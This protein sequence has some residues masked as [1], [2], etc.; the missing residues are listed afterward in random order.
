MAKSH[1]ANPAASLR[2]HQTYCLP[3]LLS[4]LP[5]LILSSSEIKLIDQRFKTTSQRLQK[6][7]DKTPASVVYFLG[8]HLPGAALLHHRQLT[9]FG[10]VSRLK[11]SLLHQTAV[12]TLTSIN[13]SRSSWF[14][15]IRELVLMYGLPSPLS[16]LFHPPTKSVYKRLI[17]AKILDFWE[18]KLRREITNLSSL[19]YFKPSYMSL[20]SPHP[21]WQTCGSNPYE[22]HKAII[23]ARMLSGRYPTEDLSKHWTDNR[24]L[25]SLPT[26][27]GLGS[28][29]HLLVSCPA[30]QSVRNRMMT[31]AYKVAARSNI[32]YPIVTWVLS[33]PYR[34]VLVQFLLDCSTIP[35]VISSSQTYGTDIMSELFYITRNWCYGLHRKRMELLNLPEYR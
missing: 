5:T 21:L 20:S 33:H 10:M 15:K 22:V 3:V 32:I 26:C 27:S 18:S 11:D 9:I 34:V 28:I 25:C 23:Q 6:L 31:L 14:F 30:L 12:W 13:L 8:G 4:G 16:L 24:G 29:E 1:R 35:L 17:K 7:H 2:A 19:R